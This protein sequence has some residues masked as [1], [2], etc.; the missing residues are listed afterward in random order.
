MKF[1][2]ITIGLLA[3]IISG[4]ASIIHG[5]TQMVNFMSQPVGATIIIDGKEYG[6]TPRSIELRRKGRKKEIDQK[7]NS[8][9]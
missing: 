4:C 1:R 6:K 3:L 7:R 2:I 8:L 9:T 5:P